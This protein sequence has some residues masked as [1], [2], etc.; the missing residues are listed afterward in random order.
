MPA[1]VDLC[2][3]SHFRFAANV[4]AADAFR[5]IDFMRGEGH[6][7]DRQLAEID[8]Q[9]ANA[10]GSIDMEDDVTAA[11]EFADS[12]DILNNTYLVV[13]MHD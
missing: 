11:A 13:Y 3:N 2:F 10:L 7:I 1:A 5:A 9:F 8:R 6:Q 4:Q 12:R